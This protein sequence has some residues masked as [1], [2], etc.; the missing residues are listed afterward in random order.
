MALKKFND[1]DVFYS[2]DMDSL[3]T[4]SNMRF[5]NA[6]A[7]TAAL[8]GALAPVDGMHTV[9]SD[10]GRS[11]RRSGSAWLPQPGTVLFSVASTN[12][13][14]VASGGLVVLGNWNTN[15]LGTRNWG[16]W[17]DINSGT[18]TT[19]ISGYFE[20]AGAVH[21]GT[22]TNTGP[23]CIWVSAGLGTTYSYQGNYTHQY[24]GAF[25]LSLVP[26][27][28]YIPATGA[29]YL[30]VYNGGTPSAITVTPDANSPALFSARYMGS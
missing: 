13:V 14:S 10:D 29:A 15:L 25:Q 3:V 8:V 20:F 27:V 21:F 24:N 22:P 18:F 26:G 16:N 30:R 12:S 17:L 28:V 19:P 11:Y 6:A 5:P 4:G 23:R 7:R 9:L 2:E 1:G